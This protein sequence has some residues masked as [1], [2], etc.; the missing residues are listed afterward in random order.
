MGPANHNNFSVPKICFIAHP[1]QKNSLISTVSLFSKSD[2]NGGYRPIVKCDFGIV[3]QEKVGRMLHRPSERLIM[4]RRQIFGFKNI[5]SLAH[6]T[7]KNSL[8]S[9]VPLF[10]K[11]DKNGGAI[12]GERIDPLK[13][14]NLRE[15]AARQFLVNCARFD[16][17]KITK[18]A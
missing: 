16:W 13:C 11:S 8:N 7:Q 12:W 18:I 3:V 4:D 9:M 14:R 17:K 5:F 6:P 15:T 1:T 2:K 10:L